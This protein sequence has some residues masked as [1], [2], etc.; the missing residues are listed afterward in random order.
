M[1]IPFL[2]KL[3]L[4]LASGIALSSCVTLPEAPLGTAAGNQTS[5]EPTNSVEIVQANRPEIKVVQVID[6]LERPWG[7]AWLPNGD[8][9]I[10]E[11]PGRLR[12]VRDGVLDP[13]AI[14]GVAEVSTVAAGQL[15][16]SQQGLS[17]IHIS[18]PTRR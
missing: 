3:T 7:M 11:R 15:F 14:A 4:P 10:T 17:L 5:P 12:I 9:L 6:G 18:E 2:F 13:K 8:I 16:A 1:L